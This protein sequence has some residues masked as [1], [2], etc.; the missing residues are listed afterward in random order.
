MIPRPPRSTRIDTLFPY[1]TLFR[2]AF[3]TAVS[4]DPAAG[5]ATS[6]SVEAWANSLVSAQQS[7]R[8]DAEAAAEARNTS[9]QTVQF[10][11]SSREGVSVRPEERRVGQ[12]W[13]STC[14]S[15]WTAENYK[16]Q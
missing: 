11:R 9:L 15:R 16:K 7:E 5:L 13:V 6:A 8:V 12:E 4:F 3:D 10:A 14:R 2:S 1:T